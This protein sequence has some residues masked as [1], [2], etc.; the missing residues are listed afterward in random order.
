MWRHAGWLVVVG[1][2]ALLAC[3]TQ[4]C[5]K[6]EENLPP[7]YLSGD[8]SVVFTCGGTPENHTTLE[9]L[10]GVSLH[11]SD[12]MNVAW[13]YNHRRFLPNGISLQIPM[14][15]RDG[16]YELGTAGIALSIRTDFGEAASAGTVTF[17]RDRDSPL[18]NDRAPE[19][20]VYLTHAEVTLEASGIM[21]P[22]YYCPEPATFQLAPVTVR[23]TKRVVIG[24]CDVPFND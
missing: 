2:C 16:T 4:P 23:L 13:S 7:E 21:P 15:L 10:E 1:A 24:Q 3:E 12:T 6:K 14:G 8:A 11:F 5:V 17:T 18:F 22:A 19:D 9:P 20:G